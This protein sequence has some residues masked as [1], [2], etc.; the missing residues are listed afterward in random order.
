[1]PATATRTDVGASAFFQGRLAPAVYSTD[2]SASTSEACQSSCSV[3]GAGVRP[4]CRYGLTRRTPSDRLDAA[5]GGAATIGLM[6][7]TN[8][9]GKAAAIHHPVS[10]MFSCPSK[11]GNQTR[12]DLSRTERYSCKIND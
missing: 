11:G 6:V 8:R 10:F 1:M 2:Q 4:S 9:T 12:V 7:G 3:P 5:S